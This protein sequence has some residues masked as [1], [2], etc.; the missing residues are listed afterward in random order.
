MVKNNLIAWHCLMKTHS[1]FA[2]NNGCHRFF[3]FYFNLIKKKTQLHS[4]TNKDENNITKSKEVK[5]HDFHHFVVHMT[6]NRN[7][8]LRKTN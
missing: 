6:M 5:C 2:Q 8:A 7:I 3:F 1:N 4:Q